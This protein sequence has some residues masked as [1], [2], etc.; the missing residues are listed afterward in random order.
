MWLFKPWD[1]L[2]RLYYLIIATQWSMYKLIKFYLELLRM[3]LQ[4]LFILYFCKKVQDSLFISVHC[5]D[6][7]T[8]LHKFSIC[9]MACSFRVGFDWAL[10]TDTTCNFSHCTHQVWAASVVIPLLCYYLP[11]GFSHNACTL[12]KPWYCNLLISIMVYMSVWYFAQET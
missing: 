11:S 5:A 6:F 8:S 7:T 3:Y 9:K 1:T 12:Q 4:N 2:L 10:K